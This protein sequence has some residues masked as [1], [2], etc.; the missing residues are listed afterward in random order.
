MVNLAMRVLFMV[1]PEPSRLP[2]HACKT[3]SG[4]RDFSLLDHAAPERSFL[5]KE[6]CG[7]GGRA[8]HG[9]ELEFSQPLID[10]RPWKD[11]LHIAID[12]LGQNA[13]HL[14]WARHRK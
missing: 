2:S 1:L 5:G 13:G 9:I 14:R 11:F 3:T 4:N 7:V 12:P 10:V 8:D 6:F